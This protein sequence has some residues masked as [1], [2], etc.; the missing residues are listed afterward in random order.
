[1]EH[2]D[3]EPFGI[4]TFLDIEPVAV[5]HL[6]RIGREGLLPGVKGGMRREARMEGR[7]RLVHDRAIS[8]LREGWREA[9]ARI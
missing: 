2:D 8:F 4:A 1:M 5:A 3:R 6:Q 9:R 7:G